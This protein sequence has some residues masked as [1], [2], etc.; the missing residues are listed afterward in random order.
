[1]MADYHRPSGCIAAAIA[2][3]FACPVAAQDVERD[4]KP[5][6]IEIAAYVTE[7]SLRFGIPEQWIY[8]VMRAE[9]AG[10][11][12]ATSPV[13]AMGLMQIMPG[14]WATLRVRYGLGGNAYN[15]HDNVIAGVA[16]IREL[17]NQF[18][19][20]GFLGAYNAGPGRYGDYVT[21]GRPLPAE[22]RSYIAAI[23]PAITGGVQ[24]PSTLIA[25]VTVASIAANWTQ[26]SLFAVRTARSDT[27][28]SAS[29]VSPPA[30][31]PASFNAANTRPSNS[32][33]AAIS[34]TSRQ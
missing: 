7:A 8:A 13:G 26:A 9:S 33:F 18:G 27:G 16:Y 30:A 24:Q 15:P 20:P 34:A 21:K 23:A 19:A 29:E 17:Y 32:L 25:P 22:T 28:Q 5:A 1:M 12:G 2:L 11:V 14:T 31:R 6:V 10:R 4:H 3:L